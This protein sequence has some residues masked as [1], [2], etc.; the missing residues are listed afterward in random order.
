VTI[1][2]ET[3]YLR[4]KAKFQPVNEMMMNYGIFDFVV[5]W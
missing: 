5:K 4:A 3:N 1:I 2:D